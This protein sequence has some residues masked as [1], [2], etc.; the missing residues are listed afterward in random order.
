MHWDGKHYR[1]AD[2]EI[3]G[4]VERI[5]RPEAFGDWHWICGEY[6]GRKFAADGEAACKRVVEELC[7][8]TKS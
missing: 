4:L 6:H 5:D 1:N 8:T 7:S 2:G 3:L